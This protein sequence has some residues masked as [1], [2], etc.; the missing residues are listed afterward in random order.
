MTHQHGKISLLP[1]L[2]AAD[3]VVVVVNVDKFENLDEFENTN[4]LTEYER[5]VTSSSS[6]PFCCCLSWFLLSF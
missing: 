6:N 4:R 2:V 1:A 3:H 5:F